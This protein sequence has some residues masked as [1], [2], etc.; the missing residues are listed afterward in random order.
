MEFIYSRERAK[1]ERA[2]IVTARRYRDA[3]MCC[4]QINAMEEFEEQAF[5]SRRTYHRHT[6]QN[7]PP[8]FW[9]T[10]GT[11]E[12]EMQCFQNLR[13][14]MDVLLDDLAPGFSEKLT[15]QEKKIILSLC[16]GLTQ[17]EIARQEGLAQS[18]VSYHLK[19]IKKIFHNLR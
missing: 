8:D 3:G 15:E 11:A 16:I 14:N 1:F 12:T 10:L 19:K 6:Q 4:E 5:R 7:L 18:T 13:R 2:W 9:D 17:Q